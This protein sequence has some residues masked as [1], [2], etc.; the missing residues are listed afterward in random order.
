MTAKSRDFLTTSAFA[1]SACAVRDLEHAFTIAIVAVG[2]RRL[3][4]TPSPTVGRS[5][6]RYWLGSQASRAFAEFDGLHLWGFLQRAQ[7][8]QVPCVYQFHHSGMTSAPKANI[9]YY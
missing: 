3:L 9:F 1:A 5:L 8:V 2:A 4:S 6:A 7:I